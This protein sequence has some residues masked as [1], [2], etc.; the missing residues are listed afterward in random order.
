M[1]IACKYGSQVYYVNDLTESKAKLICNN[2][3]SEKQ[4]IILVDNCAEDICAYKLLADCPNIRT[5]ATSD[6][7]LFESSSHLLEG[8]FIKKYL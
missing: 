4:V 8:R 1:Q 7:F 3:L 5:I 6:D 2:C